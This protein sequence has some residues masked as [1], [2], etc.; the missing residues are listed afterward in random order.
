MAG[1]LAGARRVAALRYSFGA[2]GLGGRG[3]AASQGRRGLRHAAGRAAVRAR[4]RRSAL[5]TICFFLGGDGDAAR[6]RDRDPVHQPDPH[7]DPVGAGARRSGRREAVWGATAARLRRRADRAA[8]QRARRSAAA[9]FWPLGAAFGM[10][11]LMIC[12]R[13]AAGAAPALAMQFLARRGGGAADR[14][15]RGFA[16]PDRRAAI[17][18]RARP[19][20]DVVLKCARRRRAS[21]PSAICSSIWPTVRRVGGRWWRR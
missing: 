12:N 9:A 3:R 14:G 8:A 2:L 21:R 1:A 17:P 19:A 13:K 20:C 4:A 18:D 15:G 7:R 16:A 10:A 11:W 6:R 5:A